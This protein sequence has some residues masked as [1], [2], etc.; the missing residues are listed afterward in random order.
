MDHDPDPNVGVFPPNVT[1]VNP[2][3]AD[4]VWSAPALDVVGLRL[5]VITTSSVEVHTPFVI[6]HL[7]V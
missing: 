2:Q 6:V 7:N 1:V 3:V 5:K 4:P